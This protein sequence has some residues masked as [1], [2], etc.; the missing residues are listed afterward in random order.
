MTISDAEVLRREAVVASLRAAR[1][2]EET[3]HVVNAPLIQA[4]WLQKLRDAKGKEIIAEATDI[5]T[6]QRARNL[7]QAQALR[8][9]ASSLEIL[10]QEIDSAR[11]AHRRT[12]ASILQIHTD[13]LEGIADTHARS[14]NQLAEEVV[15][16]EHAASGAHQA[17][18]ATLAEDACSIQMAHD[19]TQKSTEREFLARKR[20]LIESWDERCGVT[21]L[22]GEERV[23]SLLQAL[24]EIKEGA[25]AATREDRSRYKQLAEEDTKDSEAIRALRKDL[26]EI[27]GEI[28]LWHER[29]AKDAAQWQSQVSA[30]SSTKAE[31]RNKYTEAQRNL[32]MQRKEHE[33]KLK[34]VSLARYSVLFFSSQWRPPADSSFSIDFKFPSFFCSGAVEAEL[35]DIVSTAEC[36]VKGLE[37]KRAQLERQAKS[38]T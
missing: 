20:E 38:Q 15:R 17:L 28:A 11:A 12:L 21:R 19:S 36:V 8:A 25:A 18:L 3:H 1:A 14:L 24:K 9:S 13:R 4:D 7:R 27:Q 2:T 35:E 22:L 6:A 16:E 32:R 33:K 23:A 5:E 31:A 29:L 26:K 10:Q 30:A 37:L 34:A